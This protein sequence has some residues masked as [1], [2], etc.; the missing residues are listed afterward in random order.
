[1]ISWKRRVYV[2]KP[3]VLTLEH[4]AIAGM[5]SYETA[6]RLL[7]RIENPNPGI[8]PMRYNS[9]IEDLVRSKFSYIVASQRY[10]DLRR[11]GSAKSRWLARGVEY[12]LH[13]NLGLRVAFLDSKMGSSSGKRI[14]HSVLVRGRPGIPIDD[15]FNTEELYR[16][17][18]PINYLAGGGHG[19]IL[20]EGKP[21]NQNAS[22][23]FCF[24]EV[25]QAID[26]NQDNYLCEALKMRNLISEF[27]L[28]NYSE[29]NLLRACAPPSK[30]E[31]KG[32]VKVPVSSSALAESK[33]YQKYGHQPMKGD[34]RMAYE[35]PW[36]DMSNSPVALVGFREWVFSQDSGALASFAAATEFTFGSMVQRIMTW[37]G[38]V[39]FHYGHPDL[40]NKIFV[41]TRGGVSKATRSFHISE[42]VF[43]G[44]NHVLRGGR[45]KFK[46]YI[47]CGKGRD[48]GFDSI[49][50]FESKVSGGNGEQVMSRDVHRLATN[51]DFFRL[52][53]FYHSG[54]GFFMNSYL[55]LL[56][57]YANIWM[58][59]MLAV[60]DT[61]TLPDP[62]DDTKEISTI[63]GQETTVA[64]QQIVQIGMFSII[65]YV[66]EMILEYGAVKAIATVLIQVLQGKH[67][68]DVTLFLLITAQ[69][70][71]HKFHFH[72]L[73]CRFSCFLRFQN[74]YNCIF[75]PV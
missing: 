74:T 25:I 45:V 51:F 22:I 30:K 65:T 36:P 21:E 41:M 33:M 16:I 9:A 28:P 46:E 68:I 48:M 71:P 70:F 23:I 10:G 63:T 67:A 8:S 7:A 4:I 58:L 75:L 35:R 72:V 29:D 49:N 53:S 1:M 37:P 31:A 12:L 50:S 5:M 20:G 32:V 54:P 11:L 64:V 40:W 69:Y 27:N 66:L 15:P 18:L 39:R 56:S 57:V 17:R 13:Q 3:Q 42:D 38:S 26:M 43:A 2:Q 34:V 62:N 47:S 55:V 44:Y 52:L 59:T 61:Q 19:I 60:T 14:H 6:L 73:F 24:G